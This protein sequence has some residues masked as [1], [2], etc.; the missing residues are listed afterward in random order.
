MTT[1]EITDHLK[2]GD[3][4]VVGQATAEPPGLVRDLIAAAARV[5]DLTAFCGYSL[6]SAWN[7]VSEDGPRVRA[8]AAHGAFR[9]L[10][11]RGLLEMLPWHL[12]VVESYITSGRLKPDVVMLQ[13]APKDDEGYYNLGPTVDYAVVAAEH[14]REVLVEVNPRLPRIRS[15]RRLHESLVT[16]VVETDAELAGSPNRPAND[17]ERALA[18][19]VG[20]LIPSGATIQLGASALA[21]EVARELCKLEN[22][23]VRSGLVG[24]WLVDLYESGAMA[25]GPDTS[26]IGMALGSQRLYDFVAD[27]DAVRF[28]PTQ[29]IVDPAAMREC[30]PYVSIN[31]AIEVDLTGAINAEVVAGRYVGAVGGQVDFFRG[32]RFSVDGMAIVALSALH[33]SGESRVVIGL[34]GPATSLKSD[35]DIV[36]TEFGV[37]D[38]RATSLTERAQRL[39]AVAAP[40]HRSALA[41]EAGVTLPA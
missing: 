16:G 21:D 23:K 5:P 10:G 26:V 1:F 13:V 38:L 18:S 30:A 17:V 39:I 40:E 24:D 22:L 34:Q 20:G 35:V 27:N 31:S 11:A 12:S 36:V 32:S 25:Q 29:E 37:A 41:A 2:P 4:V 7:D 3:L 19:Y 15:A 28:A 14:A 8:Y 33:A 9:K 6:S